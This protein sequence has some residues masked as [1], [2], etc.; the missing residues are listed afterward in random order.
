MRIVQIID[1]LWW[2]GAQKMQVFLG[3]T[4]GPRVTSLAVVS[5]RASQGTPFSQSLREMGIKT[6]HLPSKSL[7]SPQRIWQITSFLRQERADIV[8]THL[9]YANIVGVLAARLVGVPVVGTLRSAGIDRAFFHPARHLLETFTLRYL[10]DRVMA[11]GYAIASAHSK[12]LRGKTIDV[13]PNAVAIPPL[14]TPER[15]RALRGEV[16]A[17]VEQPLI[18]SVGRLATPKGYA[19]LVDAFAIVHQRWPDAHL[20]VIGRGRLK[21]QLEE[22][23]KDLNL[24]GHVVLTGERDDVPEFLMACDL[25]VSSSHWEGMS[26]AILEA[27]AAGLPVV[28]TNVGDAARVVVPG[29]GVIVSPRQPV[30]L[31]EAILKFLENP[32]MRSVS[33]KKARDHIAQHYS[34]DKWADQLLEYYYQVV[35]QRRGRA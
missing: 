25:F 22:Q 30:L 33:G 27:M 5:L 20:A 32:G 1:S 26:V 16:L 14:I 8:Q 4:L 34:I 3:E 12:R 11:N 9:T 29:T 35:S 31:A 7:L 19:D 10:A 28:A 17:C 6:L 15:R 23:I 18:V 24:E 13:I 2:G 21:E